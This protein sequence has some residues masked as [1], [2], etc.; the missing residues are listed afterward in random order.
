[1]RAPV[2][3]TGHAS[4]HS[5]QEI[6]SRLMSAHSLRGTLMGDWLLPLQVQPHVLSWEG[7]SR[8]AWMWL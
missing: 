4:H 7:Q 6:S 3:C 8:P 5:G 2:G 1:M